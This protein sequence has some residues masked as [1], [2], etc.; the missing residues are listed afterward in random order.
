MAI[1]TKNEDKLQDF[2]R[3]LRAQGDLLTAADIAESGKSLGSKKL[4]EGLRAAIYVEGL[5]Q[6]DKNRDWDRLI[7]VDELMVTFRES[8]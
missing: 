5:H 4:Q 3:E 2:E 1:S 7:P 8:I 6:R